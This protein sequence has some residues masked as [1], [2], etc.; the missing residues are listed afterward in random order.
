MSRLLAGLVTAGFLLV[1][2]FLVFGS[3]GAAEND[4]AIVN[5]NVDNETVVQDL[6][7][8]TPVEAQANGSALSFNDTILVKNESGAV[9]T[10]G[11]DYEWEPANGSIFWYDTPDTADG[12]DADVSYT[13]Q[14]HPPEA[15]TVRGVL[16]PALSP[17]W[18]FAYVAAFI[19]VI[20]ATIWVAIRIGT[21]SGKASRALGGGR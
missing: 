18:V 20:G 17:L 3:V 5:Q 15:R 10:E 2:L 21:S 16:F 11:Q 6:G 12:V 19:F 1:G 14:W 4:L 8:W 13:F 9:M 7:N